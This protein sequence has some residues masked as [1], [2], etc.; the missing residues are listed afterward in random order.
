MEEWTDFVIADVGA[1]TAFAG[2]LV[3]CVPS[4]IGGGLLIAG[5]G[6]GLYWVAVGIIF[7]SLPPCRTAG[8][9]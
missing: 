7:R 8:F 1:A 9:C 4:L 5:D 6:A 2:L 3:A